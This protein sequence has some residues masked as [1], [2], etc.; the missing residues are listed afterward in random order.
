MWLGSGQ[1]STLESILFNKKQPFQK[2]V[3]FQRD[4]DNVNNRP[5]KMFS[6]DKLRMLVTP[7]R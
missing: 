5:N 6:K 4:A 7:K 3:C 2:T 1:G